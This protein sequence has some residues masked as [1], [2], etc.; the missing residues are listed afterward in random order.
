MSRGATESSTP[1]S[2]GL[3]PWPPGPDERENR[4]FSAA[5]GTTTEPVTG[6]SPDGSSVV[7]TRPVCRVGALPAVPGHS[8]TGCRRRPTSARRPAGQLT[9]PAR[10]R[11]RRT[12]SSRARARRHRRAW[13]RWWGRS[14]LAVLLVVE[15]V[16]D[17]D[18][19]V[20]LTGLA[21]ETPQR[22]DVRNR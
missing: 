12:R 19:A 1:E 5:A 11:H 4:Q 21:A 10:G 20:L 7:G 13:P 18:S 9:R 17:A 14:S 22:H 2:A 16:G 3:T 8:T 6:R 15:S